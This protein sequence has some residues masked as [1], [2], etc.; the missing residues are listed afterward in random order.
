LND[1][2]CLTSK[3]MEIERRLK[4]IETLVKGTKAPDILIRSADSS[5]FELYNY[6]TSSK[7]ILLL[8]WSAECPHCQETVDVMYPWQ[9]QPE[10]RI[11]M[12]IVA[13]SLDETETEVNAWNQ[14]IKDLA[15]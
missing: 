13:I 9:N 6:K 14:K 15:G 11:K 7:Y 5:M 4:G 8:F 2:K 12:S 10:I 3:R 1:P